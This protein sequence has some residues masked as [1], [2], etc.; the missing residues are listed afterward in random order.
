MSSAAAPAD[1]D[2]PVDAAKQH[3]HDLPFQAIH[4][5]LQQQL[6]LLPL[7]LYLLMLLLLLLH[8]LAVWPPL[9]LHQ[10]LLQLK[11]LLLQRLALDEQEDR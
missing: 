9:L 4:D 6:L 10:Q 5:E 7:P 11:L 3:S 2:S 8:L 1:E